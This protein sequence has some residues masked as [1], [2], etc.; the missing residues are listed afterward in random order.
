[1]NEQHEPGTRV[2]A[3]IDRELRRMVSLDP[4][5]GLRRRVLARLDARAAGPAWW[6]RLAAAGAALALVVL[7]VLFLRPNHVPPQDTLAVD[8]PARPAPAAPGPEATLAHEDSPS[9]APSPRVSA[10]TPVVEDLPPPPR[11]DTVFGGAPDGRIAAASAD[12][13]EAVTLPVHAETG[14]LPT[15]DPIEI[16]PIV[17]SPI[18]IRPLLPAPVRK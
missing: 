16:A 13:V 4:A 15:L 17:I 8:A 1:M 3:A 2:D 18:E 7:A 12:P 9:D 14:A 10:R 5:P 6:P 11:M